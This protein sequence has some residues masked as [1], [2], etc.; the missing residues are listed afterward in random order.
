[1]LNFPLIRVGESPE[2]ACRRVSLATKS[3]PATCN[4]AGCGD[5][6]SFYLQG[7]VF[8]AHGVIS[9]WASYV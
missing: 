9:P 4:C 2:A 7:Y 5:V 8:T 1:M 3:H 6:V